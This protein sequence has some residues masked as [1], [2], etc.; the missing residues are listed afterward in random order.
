MLCEPQMHEL[1]FKGS[2]ENVRV[3]KEQ[4]WTRQ[5]EELERNLLR[6]QNL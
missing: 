4:C 2:E 5:E 6:C 1:A 3:H